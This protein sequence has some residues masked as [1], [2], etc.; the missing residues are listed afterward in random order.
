MQKKIKRLK[1]TCKVLYAILFIT[2]IS[3]MIFVYNNHDFYE[4]PLAKITEETVT[5]S[6]EIVDAYGNADELFTQALT[7]EIKNG[8]DKGEEIK[9]TNEYSISG[10]YDFAY[11]IGDE[12]FVTLDQ[13]NNTLTG[14]IRDVKRDK[15]ILLALWAFIFTLL[16]VGKQRGLLAT[17][18]LALNVLILSWTL[19]LYI[20]QGLDLLWL[21]G[22]AVILFTILSL[23]LM[24]G[25][26]EKTYAA[27]LTTLLGTF[28]S[29]LITLVVVWY[30]EGKG[31]YYEEMSFLTRP[32]K[33]VF[34]A[35]L[36][37]GALGAVMDV[38][39]SISS[40]LY[41]FYQKDP[42]ISNQS[43]KQAGF[44]IGRDIMGTMTN[45]LFFAYVSGAIPILLVY[46]KNAS[47]LGFALSQ[48]LSLEIAR[49][50]AG[51]IGIVLTIPIGVYTSIFFINRRR[52][53]E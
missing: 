28:L 19:D 38:A 26:N 7:A 16:F 40:A 15:Y 47:P 43:L 48:N 45:I 50:L 33:L 22:F 23:L 17:I 36:F 10:A 13:K 20:H 30:T 25:R 1:S 6:K 11:K 12:V 2:F 3:S 35:G 27:I 5:D 32:Y 9:L 53:K 34:V 44:N 4:R 31:L 29:L 39:I 41:E 14:R 21:S 51:G 24:N 37:I 49:A 52:G 42:H 8:E 18:S 46:F